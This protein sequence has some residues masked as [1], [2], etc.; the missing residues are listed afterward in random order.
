MCVNNWQCVRIC[1][2]SCVC[3]LHWQMCVVERLYLW[4][5]FRNLPCPVMNYVVLVWGEFCWCLCDKSFE[6][7]VS[8]L[9]VEL[10]SLFMIGRTF[11]SLSLSFCCTFIS[12]ICRLFL[13]DSKRLQIIWTSFT[14]FIFVAGVK[15]ILNLEKRIMLMNICRATS[16]FISSVFVLIFFYKLSTCWFFRQVQR[17]HYSE[18]TL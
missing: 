11:Q 10:D 13:R 1:I 17:R 4:R 18:S 5:Y 12:T 16:F 8:L 6:V 7:F 14:N 2:G 3:V 15:Y 9:S